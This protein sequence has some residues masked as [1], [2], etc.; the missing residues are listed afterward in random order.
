MRFFFPV[1]I[2]TALLMAGCGSSGPA[3]NS[4]VP[5]QT[6][7]VITRISPTAAV[8]AGDTVTIFGIGFCSAANLNVV[9]INGAEALASTYA[10]VAAP[11]GDEVESLTFT[12]PTGIVAGTYGIYVD[13]FNN[14]SNTDVTI[15]IN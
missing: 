9:I 2:M 6:Y 3:F 13:V 10:L 11:V 12:V 7:P 5:T 4:L 14:V 8:T 15:T 1:I